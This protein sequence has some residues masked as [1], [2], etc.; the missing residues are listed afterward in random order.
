MKSRNLHFILLLVL[1]TCTTFLHAQGW[2]RIYTAPFDPMQGYATAFGEAV[3]IDNDEYVVYSIFNGDTRFLRTDSDGFQISALPLAKAGHRVIQ[4][5]DGNYVFGNRISAVPEE[6][7]ELFKLDGSGNLLWAHQFGDAIYNEAVSDLIQSSDGDYIVVGA[8]GIPSIFDYNVYI[9]KINENGDLI[10][11]TSY[12]HDGDIYNFSV[13]ESS[14]GGYLIAG[15]TD[16]STVNQPYETA[17]IKIN[18]DG[19]IAWTDQLDISMR[20]RKM[21]VDNDDYLFWGEDGQSLLLVK[22]D[23]NLDTIWTQTYSSGMAVDILKTMDNGFALLANRNFDVYLIKTDNNGSIAWTKDYGGSLN[24]YATDF[25]Q[26]PDGGYI[27]TGTA[28]G[29]G[30]DA[31]LYLIKTDSN[32]VSFTNFVEGYVLHDINENCSNDAGD[33][34]LEDWI[35]KA[36]SSTTTYYGT[37][38]SQGYY[39]IELDTG[40]YEVSVVPPNANWEAC[41][42]TE[43]VELDMNF[44][45]VQVDFS[46]QSIVL[47]PVME[48]KMYSNEYRLCETDN[49]VVRYRNSG[50]VIAEDVMVEIDFDDNL[51][52]LGSTVPFSLSGT[53][54]Y[55]FDIGDVDLQ[56]DTSF[57]VSI[58]LPCEPEMLGR[59]LC[60]EARIYPDSFCF[61]SN[62][63]WSGASLELSAQCETEEVLLKIRNVGTGTMSSELE[64][65]V[66]E[67]DVIM[68]SDYFGPLE[69]QDSVVIPQVADGTFYRLETL[70]EPFHPGLSMPSAF[71]EACGEG[72]NGEQSLGFVNQ[73]PLDDADLFKDISCQEVVASYDPNIKGAYPEGHGMVHMIPRNIPID[74]IIHFQNLGTADA[75]KVV[76]QD[77]LSEHLDPATIRPGASSHGYEFKISGSGKI[78]FTFKDI[79]LPP[80]S[81]NEE[82][83][84]G[85]VQFSV[86]QKRDLPLGTEI[87]NNAAIFFDFNAPVITNQT[88]HTIGESNISVSVGAFNYSELAVEVYPNPFSISTVFEVVSEQTAPYT[89]QVFEITGK[90]IRRDQ[91]ENNRLEFHRNALPAG[92]YF[93]SIIDEKGIINSGKIVVH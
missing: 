53:N 86:G 56:H 26:T 49:M 45:T 40:T 78:I 80:A 81:E 22:T 1:V 2:E 90:M 88:L 42:M 25:K 58:E 24:D 37:S 71:I 60:S 47:C 15:S 57:N 59:T 9:R 39:S 4:S 14:D 29:E 16:F 41:V 11:E 21:V 77:V 51:A 20:V 5:A 61:P 35:V 23:S 30:E 7:I 43:T 83:S 68:H 38:N 82:G 19:S 74:Y 85:F 50:T 12:N 46:V 75:H 91:F 69:P 93:Y 34:A 92:V 6:D 89:L 84:K 52:V 13:V 63:A 55:L 48:V 64:Y 8:K 87:Y 31:S 10:W 3:F 65:I 18:A 76:I 67:D 32:G 72:L 73:Y 70:Q 36:E 54:T 33:P 17:V 44:D 62:P 79:I 28:N 27:I 66:V